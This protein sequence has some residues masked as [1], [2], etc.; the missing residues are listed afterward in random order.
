MTIIA[1]ALLPCPVLACNLCGGDLQTRATLRQEIEKARAII[2]G[3]LT[4]PQLS[5]RGDG[6]TT[7]LVVDRVLKDHVALKGMSRATLAY[8]LPTEEKSSRFLLMADVKDGRLEVLSGRLVKDERI[9]D[10]V[11]AIVELNEPDC[12]KRLAFFARFLDSPVPEIAGDAYAE[13][14]KSADVDVARA[15]KGLNPGRLRKMVGDPAVPGARLGMGAFLLAGCG[16]DA[17]ADLLLALIKSDTEQTRS[18]L[19]GLLAGYVTLR[20]N[21]GWALAARIV[22]DPKRGFLDRY[23]ALGVARFFQGS[24]PVET[25][26]E[27]LKLM[28][29]GVAQGDLAEIPIEDL[30]RWGWW[31]LTE[32]VLAQFDKKSHDFPMVRS[33]IARYALACP[34]PEAKQ[35]IAA[36]RRRDPKFV[37]DVEETLEPDK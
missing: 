10:Y 12:A 20:A 23:A 7:D 29:A 34:K 9:I 4:N 35:F 36:L 27:I 31:D 33:A 8:Y 24:K 15:T 17:D 28:S 25:R 3:K 37:S 22:T 5:A 19:R 26:A 1:V 16:S 11:K 6:G 14:A 21:D 18:A 13:F 30:R 2:S 32:T